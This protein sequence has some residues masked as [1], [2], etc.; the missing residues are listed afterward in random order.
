MPREEG[1]ISPR[2]ST[3]NININRFSLGVEN[4]WADAVGTA[5]PL[6]RDQTFSRERGQEGKSVSLFH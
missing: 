1:K 2:V 3:T 5:E 4:E 6:S